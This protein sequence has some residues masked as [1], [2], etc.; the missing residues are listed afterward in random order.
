MAIVQ[1]AATGNDELVTVA[2]W[3]LLICRDEAATVASEAA[4]RRAAAS[5]RIE[6]RSVA[7]DRFA[8]ELEPATEF[9]AE[10]WASG[11]LAVEGTGIAVAEAI[12]IVAGKAEFA[13]SIGI[14]CRFERSI[15][16]ALSHNF[17]TKDCRPIAFDRSDSSLLVTES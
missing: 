1:I 16:K 12:D 4:E 14:R 10:R 5:S 17:P 15:G 7:S 2:F 11:T 6:A 9:V 8:V 13:G 3:T